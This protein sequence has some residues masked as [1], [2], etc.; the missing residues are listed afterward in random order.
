M[1]NKSM[2]ISKSGIEKSNKKKKKQKNDNYKN[3]FQM[4]WMKQSFG[5]LDALLKSYLQKEKR[6]SS[7]N[8]KIYPALSAS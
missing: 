8:L 3:K 6:K 4:K 2:N 5:I 7:Q 1:T